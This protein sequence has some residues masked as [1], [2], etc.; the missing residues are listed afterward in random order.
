MFRA[1]GADVIN[2]SIAPEAALA[3]EAGLPYAALAMSTDYDCWK[4]D[5]PPV[6]WE[7]I[8]AIFEAN[9]EKVVR[10]LV[11]TIAKLRG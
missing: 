3:H 2:M 7:E 1:W 10:L 11:R 9:V 5:E 8:V 4:E 6:T